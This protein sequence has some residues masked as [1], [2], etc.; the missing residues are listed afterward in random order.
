MTLPAKGTRTIVITGAS[1]GI[2]AAAARGLARRG[3]HVIVVGRDARKTNAVADEIGAERHIADFQRLAD[4]RALAAA[5]AAEHERI[6]VLANNAG[7][8]AGPREL[9]SD[10]HERTFQVNYLASFLLTHLLLD[11]LLAAEGAVIN[12]TSVAARTSTIDLDNLELATDYSAFR[13]YGRSKLAIVLFTQELHRRFHER[14]LSTA[15]CHPGIVPT[16]FGADDGPRLLRLPVV[17]T[18]RTLLRGPT[19][20]GTRLVALAASAPNW[21]SGLYWERGRPHPIATDV[22]AAS[23]QELWEVS[24]GMVGLP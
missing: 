21:P 10:G 3:Q 20:G 8:M 17:R 22:S 1:D 11:N 7:G 23:A 15:A 18:A 6:D 19:R 14:G 16:N 2:G 9:T 4:V 12:T 24:T 5:L 13:A